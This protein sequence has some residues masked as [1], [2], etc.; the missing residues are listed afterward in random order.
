M[1]DGTKELAR[2]QPWIIW[3]SF[4]ISIAS[5]ITLACCG[6]FRRRFP[7][8]FI[9]LGIFTVA[10]S[11]PLGILSAFYQTQTVFL[12]VLITAIICVSLTLFAW[13]TSK[14]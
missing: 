3:A 10:Q 5:I 9:C 11:I 8:N 12:A 7:H 2:G 1:N 13:Q 14:L 6:D 4:I